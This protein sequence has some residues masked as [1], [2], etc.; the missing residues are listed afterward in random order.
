MVV[1]QLRVEDV[2][3][4]QAL[5]ADTWSNLLKQQTGLELSYPVRQATWYTS[6]LRHEP[7]G[8]IGVEE[9]GKLIA[10]GFALSCGNV[11]WIGPMEV[12]P[13]HQGKGYGSQLLLS[14]ET[15]LST[16]GCKAVGLET[17]KDI[18]RNL[19]FYSQA[20]YAVEQDVLFLE[21]DWLDGQ[22]GG[23]LE[24]GKANVKEIKRVASTIN[25]GFDPSVEFKIYEEMG[26][27]RTL[28]AEGAVAL[29]LTDPIPGSGKAYL[30]TVL[31]EGYHRI[32]EA[33]GLVQKAEREALWSGARAMFTIVP[34][35]SELLTYLLR[36]GYK[37]KGADVRMIKGKFDRAHECS[38]FSWSG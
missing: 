29:L 22:D 1:R 2:P 8:C 16:R 32:D 25:P 24:K 26:I 10:T 3:S 33:I 7:L 38:I 5:M 15:Y 13:A 14:L 27:G 4:A 12:S 9:N 36:G 17:M 20:G 35:H 23:R 31:T 30:R 19:D 6:R 34:A 11:G 28:T 37:P 18:S 21:K